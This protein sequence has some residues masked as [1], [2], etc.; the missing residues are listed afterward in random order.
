MRESVYIIAEA[1]VNHNGDLKLAKRLVAVAAAANVDAIKFQSFRAS[2]VM[3]IDA[4]K[5]EYQLQTTDQTESQYEMVRRLELSEDS[6]HELVELCQLLGLEFLSTP[7]DLESAGML[8][9]LGLR[10]FK[11]SSGD[12]TNV[13]LLRFLASLGRPVI[14]STGMGEMEEIRSCVDIMLTAGLATEKLTLLHCT[15]SYPT[16]FEEANILAITTLQKEFPQLAIGFSDHTQGIEASLAAVALGAKVI[17]KHFT[18]DKSLPGPD[19]RASLEPPELISLVSGIRRVEQALGD[20][21]KRS[22]KTE[23]AN[24]SVA[25]KS[26]VAARDIEAGEVLTEDNLTT[27]RPGD[28]LSPL[29]WDQALGSRAV[30]AFKADENIELK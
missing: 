12:M 18:L 30:R 27:K 23:K 22:L 21:R 3:R 6:H 1:G 29:L 11:V 20:G 15:T 9:R 2:G 13:P 17:E 10:S 16:T 26:I 8:D 14:I 5:A 28:G 4:A 19:H 7:F 24:I 25:R